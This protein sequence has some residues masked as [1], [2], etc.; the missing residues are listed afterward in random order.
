MTGLNQNVLPIRDI[1]RGELATHER[2]LTVQ[3]L[4]AADALLQSETTRPVG[5]PRRDRLMARGERHEPPGG[6]WAPQSTQTLTVSV[7]YEPT[8]YMMQ[9]LRWSVAGINRALRLWSRWPYH[10]AKEVNAAKAAGRP[11]PTGEEFNAYARMVYG[12]T[13]DHAGQFTAIVAAGIARRARGQSP[14]TATTARKTTRPSAPNRG[15][16]TSTWTNKS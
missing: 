8:P 5:H 2:T 11:V 16:S 6:F 7:P 12:E 13:K 4:Y 10:T 14:S 9:F 15:S 1:G 3:V